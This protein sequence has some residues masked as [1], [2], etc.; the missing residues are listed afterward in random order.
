MGFV[1]VLRKLVGFS[2]RSTRAA[3]LLALTGYA[4]AVG[5]GSYLI[6]AVAEDHARTATHTINAAIAQAAAAVE[7]STD[8]QSTLPRALRTTNKIA[9]GETAESTAFT[10]AR[11]APRFVEQLE[12]GQ[13]EEL[14]Q[15]VSER[16][17][18]EGSEPW[19]SGEQ[20]TYR[21]MCVRLCDGAYFQVSYSTTRD[22]FAHD[23][24]ACAARCSS[25]AKLFYQRN[26]GGTP[27]T[28]K[29][30]S[31]R[32]YLAL[33]T[34]FQ[35]R[36][37]KISGCSCRADAW[38]QASKD[39][40]KLYALEQQQAEG[41]QVDIAELSRL[42]E[43]V[44]TAAT[45]R[46]EMAAVAGNARDN[47]APSPASTQVAEVSALTARTG[48]SMIPVSLAAPM[49][50]A[51]LPAED[52]M[53]LDA[54]EAVSQREGDSAHAGDGVPKPVE[55]APIADAALAGK[56]P[57]SKSSGAQKVSSKGASRNPAAIKQAKAGRHMK[58][59]K[60]PPLPA[61]KHAV[62]GAVENDGA[63][64]D[65]PSLVAAAS[66]KASKTAE[67]GKPLKAEK[68]QRVNRVELL[69]RPEKS[70]KA[71]GAASQQAR[72]KLPI[73]VAEKPI[74]GVGRNARHR[75]K[76]NS[77]FETFVRNFY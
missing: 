35:F 29:D 19:F 59:A 45:V 1:D 73:E 71:G 42:K 23:E 10:H 62:H 41:K 6:A 65:I 14:K 66:E 54:A 36:R 67:A 32:S 33:P 13:V 28:M 12:Q 8:P 52:V 75:P 58:Q 31:G 72:R 51:A 4:F 43:Q 37:G 55:L 50:T 24:A 48:V 47:D 53:M 63:E 39:R 69:A 15:Q 49:T 70:D 74:W 64:P 25:P 27:E 76:G 68:E 40:H 60:V 46:F 38:E 7:V 5:V 34:A 16:V 26:P 56:I 30:R 18:E 61:S 3:P 20:Q 9:V 11:P 44:A 21:T 17:V 22:R 2:G 77:A 57:A